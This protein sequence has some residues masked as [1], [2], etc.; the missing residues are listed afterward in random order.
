MYE[1]C[2]DRTAATFHLYYSTYAT[3]TR[4]PP[5][6]GARAIGLCDGSPDIYTQYTTQQITI[7]Q[8]KT[9]TKTHER[10]RGRSGHSPRRAPSCNPTSAGERRRHD[11]LWH[12]SAAA[13]P[14]SRAA[15]QFSGLTHAPPTAIQRG[16]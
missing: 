10:A 13:R 5:D 1:H 4:R 9:H 8:N 6:R 14:Q 12:T 11:A 16:R 2:S 3:H 15:P 7:R